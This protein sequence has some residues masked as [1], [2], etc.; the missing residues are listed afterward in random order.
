MITIDN[1]YTNDTN[2][3]K[4]KIRERNKILLIQ[5]VILCRIRISI[6][7]VI[8]KCSQYD[9]SLTFI[10]VTNASHHSYVRKR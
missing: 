4:G 2:S 6:R 7:I 10:T 1:E 5:G 3:N 9:N 8:K